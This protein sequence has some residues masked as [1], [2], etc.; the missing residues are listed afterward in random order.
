M[1]T[2]EYQ[3]Q[4]L[5]VRAGQRLRA[6]IHAAGLT[7]HNGQS[8]W[9]NCKG[10]GTCGTCAVRVRAATPLPPPAGVEAWRLGFP[11]HRR[12]AG[13]RL[14]CQVVVDRDL[15]VEK[16]PGFWGQRTDEA[17]LSADP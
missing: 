3:G 16:A 8:R 5:E 10:F 13:L 7:P 11:P 15:V 9:L 4:R 1:P 6:A 12:E 17:P 2:V 14:A